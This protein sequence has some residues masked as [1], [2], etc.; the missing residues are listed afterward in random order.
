VIKGRQDMRHKFDFFVD[1]GRNTTV[2]CCSSVSNA[3]ERL[4]TKGETYALVVVNSVVQGEKNGYKHF[5]K[6]LRMNGYKNALAVAWSNE[7]TYRDSS[8]AYDYGVDSVLV[9]NT[10][11]MT[12]E[13]NKLIAALCIR[14]RY[15]VRH[16]LKPKQQMHATSSFYVGGK[17]V[18][19]T[20]A[21]EKV[22]S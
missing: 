13:L 12:I 6:T 10:K 17:F 16:S 5:I 11:T 3:L 7:C 2:N 9:E 18:D 14:Y 19:T 22:T 20:K 4:I 15:P 1:D 8:E 21:V